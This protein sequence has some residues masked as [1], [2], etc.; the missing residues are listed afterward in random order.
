M[1]KILS[2]QDI[3]AF[4]DRLCD[5][6]ERLFAEHGTE[7]VTIRQLAAAIGVSPMT[8]YRYFKD[9]DAILASVRARGFDRHAEALEGAYDETAGDPLERAAA[10]AGAYVRF[11]LENPEAY[12]LMFDVRQAGEADYPELVRA[13]SRS[14]ATMTRHLR[15]LAAAGRL[16]GDPE[17]VGHLFWA[18]LHGPLMLQLSGM[19]PPAFEARTL[20]GALMASVA[21]E[22][23]GADAPATTAP[24][25]STG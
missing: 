2:D 25:P 22:A 21:K 1:P 7:A 16:K 12:K 3:A 8:P 23:F 14:R 20:I 11:A 4:R 9:K 17:F 18:A 10:V 24:P 5:A 6:A 19:L 13:G 15:D